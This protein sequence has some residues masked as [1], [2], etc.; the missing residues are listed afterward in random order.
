MI[1]CRKE[2]SVEKSSRRLRRR[3][4]KDTGVLHSFSSELFWSDLMIRGPMVELECFPFGR[5]RRLISRPS[6]SRAELREA[7]SQRQRSSLRMKTV[8]AASWCISNQTYTAF[9]NSHYHLAVV[10]EP[11]FWC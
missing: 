10:V 8:K 2:E 7:R 4:L 9:V 6:R 1:V 5:R 3:R 11:M